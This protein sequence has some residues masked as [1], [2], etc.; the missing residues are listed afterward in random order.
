M[1]YGEEEKLKE[2]FCLLNRLGLDYR[3]GT[4]EIILTILKLP[5]SF[6]YCCSLQKGSA[7]V[8]KKVK[9]CQLK[10]RCGDQISH[11]IYLLIKCYSNFTMG[12]LQLDTLTKKTIKRKRGVKV[13]MKCVLETL[14][15]RLGK[16]NF[17]DNY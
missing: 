6:N 13:L 7:T 2:F 16:D 9:R 3:I 5:S 11:T 4:S 10:A 1:L 14:R 12:I 15:K 17:V 8:Y